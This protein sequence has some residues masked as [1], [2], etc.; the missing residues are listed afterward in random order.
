MEPSLVWHLELL[1]EAIMFLYKRLTF[2]YSLTP[3]HMGAG[4]ALGVIDNPI[5]RERHTEH[6]CFAGSGIKG[7]FRHAA[8]AKMN[9]PN[10][11]DRIFGPERDA[12]EHAGAISFTD[13][14]LV[15]FP[16]RSLRGVYVYATSPLALK[17][18]AR[19]AAIAQVD[20]P[21]DP[22]PA[23]ADSQAIVLHDDL[24][25]K[26]N[27]TKQLVLEA[28]MFEAQNSGQ[29]DLRKIADWIA[30]KALPMA[31]GLE[32]FHNKLRE[33][34][35]LLSDNQFTYFARNATTV[36]PHV[37]INDI[38]GTAEDTGLFFTENLPPES[39]L[40][41]LLM[42]SDER[43][44]KGSTKPPDFLTADKI[45][46]RLAEEFGGKPLQIGGDATTGRGQVFVSFLGGANENA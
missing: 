9:E 3:V 21:A 45:A 23:V 2:F 5:Q 32:Y 42:A 7:A 41:S 40:V 12:S 31:P 22:L 30:D 14:Q 44:K 46:L 33:H 10:L 35:V 38:S 19:L 34:L 43:L 26:R 27:T 6:P 28:F 17:R 20:F 36:E 18:L 8:H 29:Q 4:Q 16:V 11:I 15:L 37:R 1:E 39:L 25:V 13:A 24:L